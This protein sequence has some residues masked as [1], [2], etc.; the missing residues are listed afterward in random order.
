MVTDFH[1]HV[2]PGI[3]DGSRALEQSLQMLRMEAE[4]GIGRVVATPHFYP[5]YDTP[6][7]FL[8]RRAEAERLLR[9]AMA[10]EPGLPELHIGA[11]VY[12]FHGISQS[13]VISDLTIDGSK[14]LLIEMPPPPWSEAMYREIR[15]LAEKR[16]YAP[17]IAHVDRYIGP[18]RTFGIPEKLERLPVLVQA[19]SDFFLERAT[20]SMAM[21]MLR[22]GQ[23]QLLGSDCHNLESRKPNLGPAL[24]KISQKLGTEV[25]LA[26]NACSDAVLEKE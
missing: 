1:S 17:I 23:I 10:K 6:E 15:D 9:E 22:K 21:R 20:A 5:Q 19:N 11:E 8:A 16:G 7:R 25:L 2:L 18:F 3:D 26:V 12:Y 14:Y 4:Q 13:D 24:R